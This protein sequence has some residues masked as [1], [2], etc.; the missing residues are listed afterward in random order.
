MTDIPRRIITVIESTNAQQAE[1]DL[2]NAALQACDLSDKMADELAKNDE[3]LMEKTQEVKKAVDLA[4]E[5]AN[6]QDPMRVWE[7]RQKIQQERD[8]QARIRQVAQASQQTKPTQ[9]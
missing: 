8:A 7:A 2:A 1:E 5:F 4:L 3:A 9:R 6:F